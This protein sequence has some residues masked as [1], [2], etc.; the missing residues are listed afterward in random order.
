M[1]IYT[2]TGDKGQTSLYGGT[3]V[4]KAHLRVECYG[5]VD[6]LNS[7]IG[8]SISLITD[9]IVLS[10]LKKVQFDLFT[11]GAE[12]A[13]PTDKLYLT[14]GI[15]RLPMVISEAEIVELEQWIDQWEALLPPLEYFILPSGGQSAATIHISRTVCRRAER[16][17]VALSE[18]EEIRVEII[19]YL[20]RLSDY[21]F[22]L[23]RYIAKLN[24]ETEDYW[25][26]R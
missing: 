19:K 1:K 13:T 9:E 12:L 4:S 22:V 26:I 2:K 23:A 5:S 10:Q 24:G 20:N 3:R 11:L 15:S 6:E 14:N 25:N 18:A 17:L 8:F 7:H 21:L 16:I